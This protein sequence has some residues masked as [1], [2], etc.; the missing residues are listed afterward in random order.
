MRR[1]R[2]K[3]LA[4]EIDIQLKKQA[5]D[6]Q[7]KKLKDTCAEKIISPLGLSSIFLLSFLAG[8]HFYKKPLHLKFPS[9]KFPIA[10]ALSFNYFF[11][12]A[13]ETIQ[14]WK[15]INRLVTP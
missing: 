10:S 13:V 8:R 14:L 4:C 12:L 9:L 1:L 15:K 7:M 6:C 3:L 2:K 5:L 11:A